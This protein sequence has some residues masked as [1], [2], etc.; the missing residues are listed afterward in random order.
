MSFSCKNLQ[1]TLRDAAV[2]SAARRRLTGSE[3]SKYHT[4]TD[5]ARHCSGGYDAAHSLGIMDKLRKIISPNLVRWT[6]KMLYDE[7]KKYNSK[8]DFRNGSPKA[9]HVAYKRG[10]LEEICILWSN[11]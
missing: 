8:R 4:L 10:L 6:N 11:N 3:A 2:P 7:A 9:Y 1:A 5:F